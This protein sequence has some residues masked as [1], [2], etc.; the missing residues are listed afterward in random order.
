[1]Q[2]P[3][4]KTDEKKTRI[5][6]VDDHPIVRQGLE[7]LINHENDLTVCQ[8]V[9][10]AYQAIKA[11]DKLNPDMIIVDI[12]LGEKNGLELIKDIKVQYPNLPALALSMHDESLYAERVIR[13]GARGYVMKQQATE[14]IIKAIRKVMNGQIYVSDKMTAKMMYKLVGRRKDQVTASATEILSDRELEV[15]S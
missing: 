10:N 4:Y 2:N 7:N 12:S 8:Q 3:Q 5:I 9:E 14:N 13:A 6:I 1:M 15:I 11:I